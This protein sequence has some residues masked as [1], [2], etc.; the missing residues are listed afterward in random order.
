MEFDQSTFKGFFE[1]YAVQIRNK[2]YIRKSYSCFDEYPLLPSQA[3]YIFDMQEMSIPYQRGIIRL[4]GYSEEEFNPELFNH[5]YHPDD[6]DRYIHLLKV[7]NEWARKL[8]P[9]PFTVEAS[10]DYR[11]RKKDGAYLKILRR[12]TVFETCQDKSIKSAFSFISDISRIKINTSVNLSLIDLKTGH[13]L[14][15]D[16]EDKPGPLH[17]TKREKEILL[18]LKKGLNSKTI[19]QEFECSKHTV[20]THRR[21]MLQKARCKNTPELIE[22]CTRKGII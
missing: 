11:V 8:K 6:H 14:L 3:L 21:K 1:K 17:F 18:R 2:D 10:I 13:V 22:F 9:D 12:S 15:E 4:F 7:S 16:M 19:A 5:W 20:D